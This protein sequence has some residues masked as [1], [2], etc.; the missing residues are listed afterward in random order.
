MDSR[1]EELLFVSF[2]K[3]SKCNFDTKI[4]SGDRESLSRINASMR[5]AVHSQPKLPQKRLRFD[6]CDTSKPSPPVLTNGHSTEKEAGSHV[7]G[8]NGSKAESE[9]ETSEQ[10]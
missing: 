6:D 10:S 8:T 7:N 1:K 4:K 9:S 3:L 2:E 5:A